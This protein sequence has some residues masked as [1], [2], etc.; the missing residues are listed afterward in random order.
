MDYTHAAYRTRQPASGGEV[1]AL[2]DKVR[3][4]QSSRVRTRLTGNARHSCS[5]FASTAGRTE[6]T[7]SQSKSLQIRRRKQK[8][9]KHLKNL[10]KQAKK[11]NQKKAQ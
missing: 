1:A 6:A 7:M 11:L 4:R 8:G 2:S 9:K 3:N 5:R 10:A